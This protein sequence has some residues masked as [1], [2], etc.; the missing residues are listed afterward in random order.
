M[1]R[2]VRLGEPVGDQ[3]RGQ[4]VRQQHLGAVDE[5]PLTVGRQIEA[6]TGG[7]VEVGLERGGARGSSRTL[8]G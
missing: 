5:D 3:H 1:G 6:I 8:H 4:F 2:A 7:V